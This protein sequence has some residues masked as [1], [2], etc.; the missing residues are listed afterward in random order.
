MQYDNSLNS[1]RLTGSI[2]QVT[3]DEQGNCHF[4]LCVNR[5]SGMSDSI[6][7]TLQHDIASNAELYE[8]RVVTVTGIFVSSNRIV[9]DKSKLILTVQASSITDATDDDHLNPNSIDLV[10]YV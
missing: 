9:G 4:T 2:T 10:G 6:P 1:V 7:I 8:D 5:L 3:Y